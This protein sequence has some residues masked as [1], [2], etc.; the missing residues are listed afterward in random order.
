MNFSLRT[1][2]VVSPHRLAREAAPVFEPRRAKVKVEIIGL[3]GQR[4]GCLV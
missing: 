1:L 3:L 4:F 2:A